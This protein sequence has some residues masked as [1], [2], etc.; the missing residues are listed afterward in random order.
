MTQQVLEVQVV[1]MK[2]IK[3]ILIQVVPALQEVRK[4]LSPSN[5]Q[6]ISGKIKTIFFTVN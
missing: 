3:K 4:T 1:Q 6:L 5:T 2:R